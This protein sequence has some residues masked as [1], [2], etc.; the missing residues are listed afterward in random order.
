[1]RS[2]GETISVKLQL[3][4]EV[5]NGGVRSQ[6]GK[7]LKIRRTKQTHLEREETNWDEVGESIEEV[8]SSMSQ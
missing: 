3:V 8:G 4:D 5:P 6:S 7:P 2:S 1:M